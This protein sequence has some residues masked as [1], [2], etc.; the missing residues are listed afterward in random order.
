MNRLGRGWVWAGI[1]PLPPK[2]CTSLHTIGKVG[3]GSRRARLFF[4]LARALELVGPTFAG[5]GPRYPRRWGPL[6]TEVGPI[7]AETGAH[8][9]ER[10]AQT[11]SP[12]VSAAPCTR[13]RQTSRQGRTEAGSARPAARDCGRRTK[14]GGRLLGFSPAL[15]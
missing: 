11:L 6:S 1:A 13:A 7:V 8:F 3:P 14:K 9:R 2:P 10:A 15:R 5:V 4:W 12:M